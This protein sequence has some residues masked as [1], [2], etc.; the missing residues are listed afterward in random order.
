MKTNSVA[1]NTPEIEALVKERDKLQW[2]LG[3]AT[4]DMD[5]PAMR[6][7]VAR[8]NEQIEVKRALLQPNSPQTEDLGGHQ[9]GGNLR[10]KGLEDERERLSEIL[11]DPP[12]SSDFDKRRS[13]LELTG[14]TMN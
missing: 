4:T 1:D 6:D 8:L 3:L 7:R 5:I 11:K 10:I 9:F 2:T 13:K 14:S 12:Q